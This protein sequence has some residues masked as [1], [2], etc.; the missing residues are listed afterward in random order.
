VKK[1]ERHLDFWVD[2]L[3][4]SIVNTISGDSFRTDVLSFTFDDT[5]RVQKKQGWQFNWKSELTDIKKELYKLTIQGNPDIIQGLISLSVQKDH[6]YIHL[7][8]NAPFNL[9]SKKL[10]E[11]VAGN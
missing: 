9:G 10:Y 4:N 6:V 8:E 3:T 5:K 2:K 7:L 11:G 1:K